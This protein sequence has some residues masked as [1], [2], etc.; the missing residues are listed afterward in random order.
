[1]IHP[2][3]TLVV[4]RAVEEMRFLGGRRLGVQLW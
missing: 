3:L 1:M 4:T 2:A